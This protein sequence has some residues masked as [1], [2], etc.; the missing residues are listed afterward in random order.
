RTS[1]G[2]MKAVAIEFAQLPECR[3]SATTAYEISLR[4]NPYATD[5]TIGPHV[6]TPKILLVEDNEMNQDMLRRRLE[7]R[8]FAVML[9]TDG[10]EGIRK[11]EKHLP[12]LILM[13]WN[14]PIMD[15][16]EA[17]RVLKSTP[18]TSK[19]PVIVLTALTS[20]TDR[21]RAFAAGSDDFATK[22]IEFERL[23]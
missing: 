10:S 23:L 2:S 22:P 3:L 11:A 9:A 6:S 14:L 8:G 21:E 4:P 18:L 5:K 16:G 7:R 1:E 19:I 12:D 17:T 20:A 15:G 13:D